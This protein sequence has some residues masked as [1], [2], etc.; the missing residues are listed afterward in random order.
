MN[1]NK[2]VSDEIN[3]KEWQVASAL[4]L[5]D[6]GKTL[7]FIARYRKEKTGELTETQLRHIIERTEYLNN[8][9]NRKADVIKSIEEQG[10]LTDELRYKIENAAILQEVEDLYLPYKKRKKTRAD[11]AIEKGLLDCATFIKSSKN[12]NDEYL[13]KFIDP[14]KDINSIEDVF[15]GAKDI[16]AQE[17]SED[18]PTRN[19]LR[20]QIQS[21]GLISCK[22]NKRRR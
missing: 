17:I 4:E 19:V 21:I 16:I 2:I 10:K 18:I 22:K 13:K 8:L 9:Q 15:K 20:K 1:I 3:A 14:E 11:I 7:P 6:D 5:L 12:R